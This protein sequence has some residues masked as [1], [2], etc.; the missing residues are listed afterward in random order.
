MQKSM[1]KSRIITGGMLYIFLSF[2]A[3]ATLIPVVWVFFT[4]FK[5]SGEVFTFPPVLFPKR[6]L[7]S[8]YV[9]VW[10]SSNYYRY[11]INT[12]IVSVCVV[13]GQLVTS[14]M[15]AY[16]FARLKY[17]GRDRIFLLYLGTL[18][19]PGQVTMI[20][21]FIMINALGWINTYMAL[22]I[23]LIFT[24]FGT[25]LLRQFFVTIPHELDEAAMIDGASYFTIY[26]KVILPLSKTALATLAVLTFLSTWNAFLWPLIVTRTDMM[27][28]LT[29]GIINFRGRFRSDWNLIMTST[30][31]S[32]VP[33][34]LIYLNAQKYFIEGIAMSAVKG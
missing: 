31:I 9:K 29:Q 34:I 15:A 8:N 20:P 14:S 18:M 5:A 23:P 21:S 17:R 16:S 12:V 26:S 27:R 7:W 6:F 11:F 33:M 10:A 30:I 3:L 24:A 13:T 32:I 22:I 19:I 1:K 2:C 4:S 25:F 28:T